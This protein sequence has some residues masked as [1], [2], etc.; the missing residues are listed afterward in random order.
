MSSSNE[1]SEDSRRATSQRVRASLDKQFP[2]SSPATETSPL[3]SSKKSRPSSVAVSKISSS[4]VPFG[5][6][7]PSWRAAQQRRRPRSSTPISSSTQSTKQTKYGTALPVGQK[8][9]RV[10]LHRDVAKDVAHYGLGN[11]RFTPTLRELVDALSANPK[12]FPKKKGKLKDARSADLTCENVVFRAV[13]V[14]DEAARRVLV[15]SLDPHD[16]A[17]TYATRRLRN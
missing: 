6:M 9:W 1:P 10:V 15:L 13:F 5:S 12:Q 2:R 4:L 17:Y 7:T 8:P 3:A 11:R 16:R 14:L